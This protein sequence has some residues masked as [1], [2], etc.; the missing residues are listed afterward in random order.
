[1]KVFPFKIPKT[2]EE[3]II[4][5]RDF[6]FVLYDKLHQHEEVQISYIESGEGTLIVG[7]TISEYNDDDIIV[8]GSNLPHV[9]RSEP[10][11]QESL[12]HSIFF[13]SDSIISNLSNFAEFKKLSKTLKILKMDLGFIPKKQKY[14]RQY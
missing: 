12:V 5:Q 8:L 10:R 7:D 14:R 2:N 1:M 9:L 6:E 13:N 3:S 11:E 4:Y